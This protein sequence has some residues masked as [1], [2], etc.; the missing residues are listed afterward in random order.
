MESL[1]PPIVHFAIALVITSVIFDLFGS[2]LKKESLKNAGFWTLIVGAIAVVG[3]FL[4][5]HGAEEIVENAIKGTEAYKR[6]EIHETVGT[7]VLVAVLIL[8][9]FRIFLTKKSDIRLMGIYLLAGFIVLAIVGL[10]GRIGGILVYQFG[11][12][13]KPVMEKQLNT[14][15]DGKSAINEEEDD[16]DE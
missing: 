8:T 11:V 2:I 4:T 15:D 3:A 13:V 12:G 5:G 9:A 7:V 14:T 10:Q 16:D 1:H 6:L